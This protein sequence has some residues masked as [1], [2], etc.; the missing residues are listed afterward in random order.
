MAD[1]IPDDAIYDFLISKGVDVDMPKRSKDVK[2]RVIDGAITGLNPIAG[3]A[4]IGLKQMGQNS[5]LQEWTSWKQWALGHADWNT[6]W[7]SNKDQYLR[8]QAEKEAN[9]LDQLI[10]KK[11]S[12]K[13]KAASYMRRWG[14]TLVVFGSINI[15]S[16][17]LPPSYLTTVDRENQ[18]DAL[19]GSIIFVMGGIW[20]TTK[21]QKNKRD[22]KLCSEKAM[23]LLEEEGVVNISKVANELN[24]AED[25]TKLILD[26]A[27][28]RNWIPFGI[29]VT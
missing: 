22:L 2:G 3:A 12:K 28:K 24:M 8:Q 15:I 18:R 26:R 25:R 14:I 23:S 20:F 7:G 29:K 16:F 5:K 27:Q 13:P 19:P 21:G 4:N 9:A 10:A 17:F 6:F 11:N 1:I